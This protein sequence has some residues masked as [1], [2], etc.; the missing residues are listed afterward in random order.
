MDVTIDFGDL[1]YRKGVGML[2]FNDE[3]KV[4]VGRR[5][6]KSSHVYTSTFELWQLPQG[7]ID[8]GEKPLDA[9]Y[10]ELYEETGMKSIKLLKEAESWFS[11]DFPENITRRIFGS[12]YRGQTQK[13]FA[14]YFMGD[15]SEISLNSLQDDDKVEFDQWRWVDLEKVPSM[16]VFFKR[17]VY[18]RVVNEFRNSIQYL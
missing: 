16:V 7:G 12:Q 6:V 11:Y 4:W 8:K 17:H 3:W 2:V 15:P 14:F 10:R 9:A 1:P 5:L 13:W 18:K